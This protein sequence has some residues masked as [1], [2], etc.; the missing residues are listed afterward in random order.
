MM[1]MKVLPIVNENAYHASHAYFHFSVRKHQSGPHSFVRY[2][3]YDRKF[4]TGPPG[5]GNS[6]LDVQTSSSHG[7]ALA[8]SKPGFT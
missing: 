6:G 7:K 4:K 1:P 2:F 8:M 3:L 5:Y